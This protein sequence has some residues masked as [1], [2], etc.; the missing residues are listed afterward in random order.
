MAEGK[1][2]LEKGRTLAL[3]LQGVGHVKYT[4]L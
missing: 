1:A 2:E 4:D 3:L